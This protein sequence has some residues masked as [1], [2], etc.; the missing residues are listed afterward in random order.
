MWTYLSGD[1]NKDLSP[2]DIL[3]SAKQSIK[4]GC[5]LVFHDSVKAFPRLR[6]VLPEL[7]EFCKR[8]KYL[9]KAL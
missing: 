2:S 9:L 6:V 1:Y 5:I 7:L 8:E 4:P 3:R